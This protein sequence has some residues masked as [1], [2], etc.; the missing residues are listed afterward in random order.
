[1]KLV[2]ENKMIASLIVKVKVRAEARTMII[3]IHYIRR[4]A[5]AYSIHL[6]PIE[7]SRRRQVSL[8]F[9]TMYG[10]AST[11]RPQIGVMLYK[12]SS[13]IV[14]HNKLRQNYSK[15]T[16]KTRSITSM[17]TSTSFT[18]MSLSSKSIHMLAF[19]VTLRA[20]KPQWPSLTAP[21]TLWT[22][23]FLKKIGDQSKSFQSS[24]L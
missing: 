11:L 22:T 21:R 19:I 12:R 5:W 14:A 24:T 18:S 13:W 7:K 15:R 6:Q 16:S 17:V 23:T 1:M 2:R 8:L 10:I 3:M 4:Q 20:S 9:K